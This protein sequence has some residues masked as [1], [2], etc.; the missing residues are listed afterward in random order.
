[1]KIRHYVL[2]L[3]A[4]LA[5]GPAMA[6]EID[7]KWNAT[8]D[9]PQ[10]PLELVFDLKAEGEKLTGTLGAGEMLPAAPISEGLVKG[11]DV[12]FKFSLALMPD[13]PP[14]VIQYKGKVKGDALD[15]VST[16]DFGQGP[17]ETQVAAKRV[18]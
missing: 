13:A 6:A 12:S 18:K 3:A 4:A 2:G 14:L 15:L 17:T 16:L 5:L 8:V 1:M 11:E 7:G 10:G 9:G